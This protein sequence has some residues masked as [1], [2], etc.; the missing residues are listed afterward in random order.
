MAV[1]EEIERVASYLPDPVTATVEDIE[2]VCR[3]LRVPTIRRLGL[4][5][6]GEHYEHDAQRVSSATGF[7]RVEPGELL[8]TNLP[9]IEQIVLA[10]CRRRGMAPSDA[11][12]MAAEIKLRLVDNDYAILR[13]YSGKSHFATYIA[14]VVQRLMIDSLRSQFGKW[15]DSAE[16]VRLGEHA[17]AI[18]RSLLRDG[19]SID[20]A[21][22]QL[23]IQY[24]D[25]T[26]EE[27]ETTAARLPARTRR[28]MVDLE[29]ASR[30]QSSSTADEAERSEIARRISGVVS[31]YIDSLS[32]DEQFVLRLRFESNMTVAQ[33]ARALHIDQQLLYR[34]LYKHFSNLREE[35]IRA[36]VDVRAVE[37]LIGTDST[38]LDFGLKTRGVRPSEEGESTVADIEDERS[39]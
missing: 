32:V 11:E 33:I 7:R 18:E 30:V 25:I 9:L 29:E 19:R 5:V 20:D 4:R 17:I 26:R 27:I 31:A 36:N 2:G 24:P 21:L 23:R 15:H 16:A 39:S 12:E 37:E 14:A 1:V 8:L 3:R 10:I 38:S 34:R 13:N 22:V 6:R 35:L 28:K